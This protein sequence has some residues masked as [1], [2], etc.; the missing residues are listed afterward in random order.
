MHLICTVMET[1]KGHLATCL[2]TVQ[3]KVTIT[4][5]VTLLPMSSLARLRGGS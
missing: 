3:N 1:I 2:A 5:M 4:I